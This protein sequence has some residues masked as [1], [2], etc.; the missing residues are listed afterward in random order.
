MYS[1]WS[2]NY[3]YA[4]SYANCYKRF[5]TKSKKPLKPQ[6]ETNVLTSVLCAPPIQRGDD[7]L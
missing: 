5:K 2:K 3:K 6:K 7:T 4:Y 1:P